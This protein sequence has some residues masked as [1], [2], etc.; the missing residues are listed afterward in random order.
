MVEVAH[1]PKHIPSQKIGNLF[2]IHI[3]GSFLKLWILLLYGINIPYR[4]NQCSLLIIHSGAVQTPIF[5][6]ETHWA[7]VSPYCVL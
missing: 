4:A 1:W 5:F 6:K 2:R 3:G 7:S